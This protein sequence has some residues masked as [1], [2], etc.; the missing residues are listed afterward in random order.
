MTSGVSIAYPNHGS[1][2]DGVNSTTRGSQIFILLHK[3]HQQFDSVGLKVDVS[4]E[5]EQV[6]VLGNHFFPSD[7]D[8]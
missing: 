8:T 6:G 1:T 4:V 7:R 2:P 3:I 5:G